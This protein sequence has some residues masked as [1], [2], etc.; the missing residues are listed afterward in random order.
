MRAAP[1]LLAGLLLL[2]SSPLAS[3]DLVASC[4]TGAATEALACENGPDRPCDGTWIAGRASLTR[5]PQP[6]GSRRDTADLVVAKWS[7]T[8]RGAAS[9]TSTA[10]GVYEF[11][12]QGDPYGCT[13]HLRRAGQPTGITEPCD[14][15]PPSPS[16]TGASATWGRLLP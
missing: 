2:G 9:L 15:R 4:G 12:W 11:S 6:D 14:A 3:A 1:A 13:I 7:G 5:C 10:P 8:D 16:D